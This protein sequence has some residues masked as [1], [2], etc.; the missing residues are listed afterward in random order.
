M[1]EVCLVLGVAM[2]A[3]PAMAQGDARCEA[4]DP[5]GRGNSAYVVHGSR[6]PEHDGVII[7]C[8]KLIEREPNNAKAYL[9]RGD[10]YFFYVKPRPKLKDPLDYAPELEDRESREARQLASNDWAH[11]IVATSDK[12]TSIVK[13]AW[14]RLHKVG[15]TALPQIVTG[16]VSSSEIPTSRPLTPRPV[17]S[18][19][20]VVLDPDLRSRPGGSNKVAV[21]P[22]ASQVAPRNAPFSGEVVPHRVLPPDPPVSQVARPGGKF[23]PNGAPP[24]QQ[25]ATANAGKRA[26]DETDRPGARAPHNGWEAVKRR[27]S[28]EGS[29]WRGQWYRPVAAVG[30]AEGGT[31]SRERRQRNRDD[32]RSPSCGRQRVC[33]RE[34]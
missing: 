7:A 8:T 4:R 1:R 5:R 9:A 13:A 30:T 19:H 12:Q 23:K 24:A 16:E 32:S 21:D 6:E 15:V 31:S 33:R 17:G 11:A 10:Q 18:P 34:G 22:D 25:G 28:Q 14:E 3:G 29:R 26:K 2:I 27:R 20:Q